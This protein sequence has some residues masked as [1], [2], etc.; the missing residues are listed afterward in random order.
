MIN[1]D[2]ICAHFKQEYPLIKE[3]F[4]SEDIDEYKV[5]FLMEMK[6]GDHLRY[7]IP[8]TLEPS[9]EKVKEVLE[10]LYKGLILQSYGR[11]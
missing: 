8:N 11:S 4:Y 1:L 3:I 9:K 10:I 5:E 6:N 2:D 7:I